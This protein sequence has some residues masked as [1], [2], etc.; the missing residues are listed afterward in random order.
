M[1]HAGLA[2]QDSASDGLREALWREFS[3]TFSMLGSRCQDV[4]DEWFDRIHPAHQMLAACARAPSGS[5][6]T[7]SADARRCPLCRF[8]VATL[9]PHPERLST[10]NRAAIEAA[11]PTWSIDQGLCPQCLDLYEAHHEDNVARSG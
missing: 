10:D 9:D 8:P 6:S 5:V 3:A 4:F 2:L 11:F 1:A 7:R